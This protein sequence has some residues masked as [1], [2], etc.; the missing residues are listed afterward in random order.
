MEK[1]LTV[2]E[3][4]EFLRIT[5][6]TLRDWIIKGRTPAYKVG[7]EWRLKASELQQAVDAGR[8]VVVK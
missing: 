1:L 6:K 4:S 5:E 7:D 3:A 8:N 2:K